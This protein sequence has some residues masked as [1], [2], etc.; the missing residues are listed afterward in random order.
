M[1]EGLR[2]Q[3]IS[4]RIGREFVEQIDAV[5]DELFEQR[6]QAL[7]WLVANGRLD[8]RVALRPHG[9]Y[10][11][12]VGIITDAAED[13]IVFAGSA[14]KSAAALLPTLN[15]EFI[16]VF[17]AWRE[18][19]ADWH[20]PHRASF[21]RLW[22]NNSP[23]TA[24]MDVPTAI[25]DRLLQVAATLEQPPDPEREAAIVAKLRE[26]EQQRAYASR[27]R[28]PRLPDTINGSPLEMRQ[29]QR[30]ALTAW[31]AK[32]AFHGIFDLATGAGKTITAAYAAVQMAKKIPGLTVVI[33][34][35]YQSLADQW[36]EILEAFN[37]RPVQCYVSRANW[38]DDLQ[39]K[40]LTSRPARPRSR[41]LS[42]LTGR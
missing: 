28:G 40:I 21:V 24:V 11:D 2:Q 5:N 10:H 9:I 14:N 1:K 23:G 36:C 29:H 4:E 12:K 30:D 31:Q 26:A 34:A 41:R 15:Y 13:S 32:G 6:F 17:P 39:R 20:E 3:E 19:L 16:D 25:R 8:I 18:D 7:A 33:A 42:S 27:P 35:P 22:S 37:I 38:H